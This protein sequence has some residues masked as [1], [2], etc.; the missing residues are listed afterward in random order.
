M[1]FVILIYVALTIAGLYPFYGIPVLN[2]ALG[3]PLGAV[4][5]Y[6]ARHTSRKQAGPDDPGGTAD[7]SVL[8]SVMSWALATS[9]M[10]MVICWLQLA[11]FLV[12]IRL[13]GPLPAILRW[14][15]LVHPSEGHGLFPS[16]ALASLQLFAT[17]LAPG[18]QVLTTVFGGVVALLIAGRREA[19]VKGSAVEQRES[20]IT[21]DKSI[22]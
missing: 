22:D 7:R 10:T 3:F 2:I 19:A 13:I 20:G 17:L 18:I 12:A 4:I 8:G 16:N 14:I 6:H 21:T 11:V 15:P 9:G 5:V 1:F